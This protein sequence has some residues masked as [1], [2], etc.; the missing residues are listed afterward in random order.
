MTSSWFRYTI[1]L[2]NLAKERVV[3]KVTIHEAKTHLSR[4]IEEVTAGE[5]V[6]ISKAGKPV[7]RLV[8]FEEAKLPKRKLGLLKGKL[9]IPDDFDS[10]MPDDLLAEFEGRTD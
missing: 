4:L 5:E 8:R 7:A 3:H 9:A 2:A 6:I 1:D 10:P